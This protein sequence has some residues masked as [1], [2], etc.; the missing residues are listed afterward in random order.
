M[1][2]S[3]LR[4]LA[5]ALA[6]AFGMTGAASAATTLVSAETQKPDHPVTQAQEFM[7]RTLAERTSGE[8]VMQ[9][10]PNSELGNESQVVEKLRKGEIAMGRVNLAVLADTVPAVKLLSLPYLF[11]SRDH[12]WNVLRGD[13]GKR[14]ESEIE[15]TGMV[16]ITFFD[17]GTRNFYSVK[18]PIRTRS[19]FE[20]MRIRVQP[21]PVYKDLISQLGG[22]PVVLAYDKVL[23]ALKNNEIDA[24]EN[25]LPSYVSTDH[26]KYAKYLSL[27]EHSMV[28]EVLLMSKKA[29]QALPPQQQIVLKQSAEQASEYMTKL[30]AGKE[31]EALETARKA[32][33]TIIPKSQLAQTGI[34]SF[35]VKLYTKYVTNDKDLETVLKIV[36]AK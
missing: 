8:L 5:A 19:D 6:F 29:W 23:D 27:D 33:V 21:S 15:Q 18:K 4:D 24:A 14:M 10:K 30:W 7:A 22:V 28:P 9:I 34:E 16:A 26:Y 17:S 25:N 32:G 12:M 36:S 1:M 11:R 20:G 35:A 13:F 2:K 31:R 3:G